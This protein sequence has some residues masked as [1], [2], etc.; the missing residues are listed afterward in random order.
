MADPKN[1][2]DWLKNMMASGLDPK[3]TVFNAFAQADKTKKEVINAIA[4]EFRGYLSSFDIKEL[5]I[6]LLDGAT[7]EINATVKVTAPN[8]TSPKA[9]SSSVKVQKATIKRKSAVKK[10]AGLE[11]YFI[12]YKL[13]LILFNWI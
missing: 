7:F 4:R 6:K 10:S 2:S 5:I 9:K 12:S 11:E 1:I 3:E 8:K 13:T